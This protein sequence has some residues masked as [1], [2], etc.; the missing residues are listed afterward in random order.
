M[1]FDIELESLNPSDEF[2]AHTL[3]FMKEIAI[4]FP[5]SDRQLMNDL[6]ISLPATNS[7]FINQAFNILSFI[8]TG[9][10]DREDISTNYV[11]FIVDFFVNICMESND[12]AVYL[13][14]NIEIVPFFFANHANLS[15]TCIINMYKIISEYINDS[16]EV[17]EIN[18]EFIIQQQDIFIEDIKKDNSI[19]IQ[20]EVM[21]LDSILE[22]CSNKTNSFPMIRS[23]LDAYLSDYNGNFYTSI[24]QLALSLFSESALE[25][26]IN[27]IPFYLRIIQIAYEY[28]NNKKNE[29]CLKWTFIVFFHLL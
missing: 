18:I 11:E 6:L 20:E 4:C 19:L 9:S 28:Y 3:P 22:K 15:E 23:V 5:Y 26:N 13:F 24:I 8:I 7:S 1:N 10:N 12:Q 21:A 2:L 29:K 16:N 25:D 14:D 27:S 17:Y